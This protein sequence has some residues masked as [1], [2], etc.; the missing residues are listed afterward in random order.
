M[1][2]YVVEAL[3]RNDL[4]RYAFQIRKL[5]HLENTLYFPIVQLLEL[6]P[7]IFEDFSYEI[8]EDAK[9]PYNV[10]GD[11]EIL[12]KHIRI[13]NNIYEG[14]CNG[15]GRDRMT[16]AHEIAHFLLLC[17]SGLK[18]ERNFSGNRLKAY[19]DPEWQAKALAGEL[20]CGIHL[21]KN[22][23]VNEIMKQCGVSK[24]AAQYH[25]QKCKEVV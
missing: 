25:Y 5:L 14:A 19:N 4:R 10:H 6:L 13:K 12:H 3:S 17:V 20:M 1:S 7:E 16:V 11:T 23:P 8:V 24:L 9:L 21:I 18:L 15:N 2:N 22:M